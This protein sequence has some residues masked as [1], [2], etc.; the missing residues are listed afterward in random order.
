[1][2]LLPSDKGEKRRV[3]ERER[4]RGEGKGIKGKGGEEDF[5]AFPQF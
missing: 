3:G 5:Q 4:R 2:K 1:M